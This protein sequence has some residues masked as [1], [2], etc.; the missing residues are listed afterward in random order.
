M[1][2][3]LETA[4]KS[5]TTSKKANELVTRIEKAV[6]HVEDCKLRTEEMVAQA[7][8]LLD[9]SQMN[10]KAT[11]KTNPNP[12]VEVLEFAIPTLG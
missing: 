11:T 1:H 8:L 9:L 7:K 5:S 3:S 4:F 10:V 6:K 2:T 12:Q